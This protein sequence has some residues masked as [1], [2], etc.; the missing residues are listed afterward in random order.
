MPNTKKAPWV[1]P[2]WMEPYRNDFTNTG[3][4]SIEELMSD[5]DS[6]V[7]NNVVRAALIIAVESQVILLSRL[8]ARGV[9]PKD[10][11]A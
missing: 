1:M 8:H 10:G 3:G 9:L 4:N 5:S 7:R 11:A 6:N 2:A